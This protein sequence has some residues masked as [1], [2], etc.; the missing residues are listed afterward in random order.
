MV[1]K[2]ILDFVYRKKG[3]ETKKE[4]EG[5]GIVL[6]LAAAEAHR[7]GKTKLSQLS[8][9]AIPYWIVQVSDTTSLL[10]SA[11]GSSERR[12]ELSE[13]TKLS[14]VRRIISSEVNEATHIPDVIEKIIPMVRILDR[15]THIM[16]HYENPTA[17][18]CHGRLVVEAELNSH[19]NALESRMDSQGALNASEEFQKIR[20]SVTSRIERLE[21]LKSLVKEKLRGHRDVLEN[22]VVLE[23]NKWE[24]RLSA[25]EDR[26]E[27]EKAALTKKAQDDLYHL[28]ES[29]KLNLSAVT[30]N[31]A[32][33]ISELEEFFDDVITRIR[34]ARVAIGQKGDDVEGTIGIYQE[35]INYLSDTV[36]QYSDAIKKMDEKSN[37]VLKETSRLKES[38]EAESGATKDSVDSEISE[39]Q[40]RLAELT[41]ERA[42]QVKQLETVLEDVI[43]AIRRIEGA[44]EQ[45][46]LDLQKEL[47]DLMA[48]SLETDSFLELSPLTQ[49]YVNIY[50]ACYNDGRYNVLAPCYHPEERIPVKQ[51]LIPLDKTLDK[52]LRDSFE[53]WMESPTFKSDFTK[54]C[55]S[56]NVL[57]NPDAREKLDDGLRKLQSEQLLHE[58]VQ[59]SLVLLWEKY[60]GRCPKCGE[61]TSVDEKFC[62]KCGAPL[63]N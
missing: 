2:L 62:S 33:S 28:K 45:R 51:K 40:K 7:K 18:A 29:Q 23:K 56:G 60:E 46:I 34:N 42:K 30:A 14:E 11:T 48:L 63:D 53:K 52:Y 58:G 15:N 16:A 35:M 3:K 5:I 39:K 4:S 22:I 24:Q 13:N 21:E 32:R 6:A 38:L 41:E 10:L 20:D 57:L 26:T 50:V 1:R 59:E 27:S 37:E 49:F 43:I 9:I 47:L 44:I 54:A 55:N 25:F 8:K 17:I 61:S 19:M 12:I 31:F 36:P